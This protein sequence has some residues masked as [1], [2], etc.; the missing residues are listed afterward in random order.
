MTFQHQKQ[1][2]QLLCFFGKTNPQSDSLSTIENKQ[3]NS[4][5]HNPHAITRSYY[6]L[7]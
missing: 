7:N 6:F 2:Y 1:P 3:L 4:L 5:F